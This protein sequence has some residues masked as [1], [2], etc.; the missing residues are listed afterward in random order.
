M[1]S[2]IQK[3]VRLAESQSNLGRL[4]DRTAQCV[5]RWVANGKPSQKGAL[6]IEK[7]LA[8]RV[9]RAE[10]LPELFAPLPDGA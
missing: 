4:I 1:E 9:T 6:L 2:G 8:G 3:A 7:A 10:L 5:Q